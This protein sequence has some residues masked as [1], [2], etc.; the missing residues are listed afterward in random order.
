[1]YNVSISITAL[2]LKKC[3]EILREM[4]TCWK[5]K[6]ILRKLK[7]KKRASQKFISTKLKIF[8]HSRKFIP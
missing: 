7:V 1:M 3:K 5:M 6:E 8:G 2:L 4:I